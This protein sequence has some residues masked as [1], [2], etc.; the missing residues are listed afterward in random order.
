[1]VI[2]KGTN[3]AA[4]ESFGVNRQLIKGAP[5]VTLLLTSGMGTGTADMVTIP[6]LTAASAYASIRRRRRLNAGT[7]ERGVAWRR[8]RAE[9]A[10]VGRR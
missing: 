9:D 1:M 2:E 8:R 7:T 10:S 3:A 6:F 5:L 4:R